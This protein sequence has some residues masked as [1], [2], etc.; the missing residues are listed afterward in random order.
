MVNDKEYVKI[1]TKF[2][3]RNGIRI[4]PSQ[5]GLDAFCLRIPRDKY[6]N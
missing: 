6:R 4:Y 1:F 5:Y 2:I 3:T